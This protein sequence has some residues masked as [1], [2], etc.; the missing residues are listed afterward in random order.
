MVFNDVDGAYS[1]SFEYERKPDCLAC[2]GA[3]RAVEVRAEQALNAL[4]T[5]LMERYVEMA[6]GSNG[7]TKKSHT[8]LLLTKS[9]WLYRFSDEFQM[10][11]PGLTTVVGGKNKTLYMQKPEALEEAT[12]KNLD[13]SLAGLFIGRCWKRRFGRTSAAAYRSLL[14]L[15]VLLCR[16]LTS[17]FHIFFFV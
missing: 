5:S 9:L 3:P 11:G 1:Y 4:I 7:H 13:L 8:Q 17:L 16:L 15:L 12:R 14:L 2:S 6:Q 10:R